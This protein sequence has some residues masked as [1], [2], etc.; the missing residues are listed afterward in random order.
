MNPTKGRLFP[1]K[2]CA[3]GLGMLSSFFFSK[4]SKLEVSSGAKTE[5]MYGGTAGEEGREGTR[6]GRGRGQEEEV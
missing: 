3:R 4:V 2:P 1:E 6:G 5:G